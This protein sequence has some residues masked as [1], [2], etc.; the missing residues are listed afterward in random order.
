MTR[1]W[2][3]PFS[4]EA[5]KILALEHANIVRVHGFEISRPSASE[6]P[7]AYVVLDYIEGRSLADYLHETSYKGAFPS[8]AESVQLFASI[9]TAID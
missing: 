1:F 7:V 5:Q 6:N 8:V 3:L 2:N 4:Q 9:G